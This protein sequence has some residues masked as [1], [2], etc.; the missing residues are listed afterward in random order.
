[1][2]N[3]K[4]K[5][6]VVA[7]MLGAG[8]GSYLWHKSHVVEIQDFDFQKDSAKVDELFHK[9]DNWYW[10]IST[11]SS[12]T[13]NVDFML[14]HKTSSQYE[15][16]HDMVVKVLK[17][18]DNIAGFLA[19]YP[20]SEHV[21][22]LLFLMVDQDFRRQGIAKKLLKFAVDDMVSRGAIKVSL[23]TRNNNFKAQSLY[24]TFGFKLTSSDEEFV[25][26][27]WYKR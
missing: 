16:K 21:W 1:M 14:R 27:S 24:K 7:L 3:I 12:A 4:I 23:A 17:V 10:M 18:G 25:F 9:G 13:Y 2:K 5:V 11:G 19:Y 22:Q 6:L 8:I 26:F 15:K 20:L